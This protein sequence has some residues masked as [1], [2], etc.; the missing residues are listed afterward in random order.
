VPREVLLADL[1]SL[2]SSVNEYLYRA[3]FA[4]ARIEQARYNVMQHQL[5]EL[6]LRYGELPC[7]FERTENRES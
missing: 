7:V 6:Q 1:K 3:E 4:A 5:R 2:R